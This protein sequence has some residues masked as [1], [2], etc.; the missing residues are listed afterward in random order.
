MLKNQLREARK[1]A[2]KT[3]QECADHIGVNYSTYSGY[4]TGKREPDLDKLRMLASFLN[5]SGDYL[6]ET[7]RDPKNKKKV[8]IC[9]TADEMR[10]IRRYRVL[11]PTGKEAASSALEKLTHTSEYWRKDKEER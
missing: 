6:L 2:K 10:L 3:Q 1:A 11:N 4:E 8:I 5:V 9:E 7:G